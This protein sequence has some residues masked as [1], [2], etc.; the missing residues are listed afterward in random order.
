MYDS[1]NYT[2]VEKVPVFLGAEKKKCSFEYFVIHA[3]EIRQV[4]M[5]KYLEYTCA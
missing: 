4:Q 2:Y 5:S 3:I 1:A